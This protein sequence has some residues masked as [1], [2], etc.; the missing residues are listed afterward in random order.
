MSDSPRAFGLSPV[1]RNCGRTRDKPPFPPA[2]PRCCRCPSLALLRPP[3]GLPESPTS[4]F[5]PN[6]ATFPISPAGTRWTPPARTGVV[7]TPQARAVGP[8]RPLRPNFA[9][10]PFLPAR[11]RWFPGRDA[12]KTVRILP[13]YSTAGDDLTG[14]PAKKFSAR[15][16]PA[17]RRCGRTGFPGIPRAIPGSS[18]RKNKFPP[19]Y[20]LELPQKNK[21]PPG[22]SPGASAEKIRF[23]RLFPGR[24]KKRG[25]AKAAP[26]CRRKDPYFQAMSS[27]RA[28]R[29]SETYLSVESVGIPGSSSALT[30]ELARI[31]PSAESSRYAFLSPL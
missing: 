27:R 6:F 18:R 1:L 3:Q 16:S 17:H 19:A 11:P 31:A 20:P 8:H 23:P 9:N 22:S 10:S 7:P 4:R 21:F 25:T 24:N 5:R 15:F 26:L 13:A 14:D 12:G 29:T 2:Q 30:P 28:S